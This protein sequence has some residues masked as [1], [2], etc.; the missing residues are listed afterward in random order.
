MTAYLLYEISRWWNYPLLI[1]FL[2]LT[3]IYLLATKN[4]ATGKKRF[5][6]GMTLIAV[7]LGSPLYGVGHLLFSVHMGQMAILFFFVPPLL[8]AGVPEESIQK[9]KRIDGIKPLAFLLRHPMIMMLVFSGL[10]AIYHIPFVFDTVMTNTILYVSYH[11]IMMIAAIG[12]WIPLLSPI[13][14]YFPE[15]KR[16]SYLRWSSL[17][18][19]PACLLLVFAVQPLYQ[20]F[21][22]PETWQ[23]ALD[24]CFGM[25]HLESM[26]DEMGLLPTMTDQ[27]LGGVIML[28]L[29]KISHLD[30][31]GKGIF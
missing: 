14:H 29:H 19:L 23:S 4:Y 17:I 20:T 5:I 8:L 2:I 7:C 13:T 11:V 3:I 31:G 25:G 10:F 28:A 18:I 15:I 1:F 27:R 30:I 9:A 22:D 16:K 12:M 26:K 21:H 6:L 24:A